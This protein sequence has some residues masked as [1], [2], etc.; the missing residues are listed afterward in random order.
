MSD[1][2]L[3]LCM[4]PFPPDCLDTENRGLHLFGRI[5]VSY[6]A[7]AL[8]AQG[9]VRDHGKGPSLKKLWPVGC[10]T[11]TREP[12]MTGAELEI[13][14]SVA[15][16]V[17]ACSENSEST[18]YRGTG[19]RHGL[20]GGPS[21]QVESTPARPGGSAWQPCQYVLERRPLGALTQCCQDPSFSV[22]CEKGE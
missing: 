13:S 5:Y 14:H 19:Q 9:C 18:G 2:G 16:G 11:D 3:N 12:A 17:G 10:G 1:L 20:D 22:R 8:W 6:L 15:R 7:G 4:L 21:G